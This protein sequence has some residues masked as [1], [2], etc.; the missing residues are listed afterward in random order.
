[1]AGKPTVRDVLLGATEGA[2][3]VG[4]HPAVVTLSAYRSGDLPRAEAERIA[5]HLAL[6]DTCPRRLLDLAAFEEEQAEVSDAELERELQRFRRRLAH[7]ED[8]SRGAARV[9]D[10]SMRHWPLAAAVAAGAFLLGALVAG[11]VLERPGA[12]RLPPPSELAAPAVVADLAP[13]R[14]TRG[15]GDRPPAGERLEVPAGRD[16]TLVLHHPAAGDGDVARL[17]AGVTPPVGEPFDS[18][19]ERGPTGLLSLT[20]PADAPAGRYRIELRDP[21]E[22]PGR[23][24][25]FRFELA[26][27]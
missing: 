10:G 13:A 24:P 5:E 23:S 17:R 25:V 20:L 6:C 19:L 12:P 21:D 4:E 27:E 15:E 3:G 1:M 16:L 18:P 2:V 14:P 22:L 8:E 11:L 26:R 7:E 9:E